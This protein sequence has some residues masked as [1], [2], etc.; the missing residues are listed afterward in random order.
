MLLK[1]VVITGIGTINPLGNNCT[2][3][4][5][6]LDNGVS[7]ASLIDRFDTSLFKT[8]F[9]C[10][11]LNFNFSDYGF[12]RKEERKNDRFSQFALVAAQEA[13]NDCGIDL[14]SENLRRIGVIVGSGVGGLETLNE[15]ISGYVAGQPP[16]YSPFLIPKIITNIAAG[17]IS[18]KYGFG[19]PNFS[20]TSACATSANAICVAHQ[21]LQLGKAN[22]MLAGGSEAPLVVCGV[23]GFNAMHALSTNN[24]EFKSASRPFDKTRDGFVMAEGAGM[25]MLEEYEHAKSRG[26]KIYAE[27]AG[28][29]MSGDSYHLTS[30]RP[31]GQGAIEAMEYALEDA[32]ITP[33]DVDYINVHGTSTILGDVAELSAVKTLFKDA[34]YKVNISST[35]SMTGHLL[36]AAG[37]VEAIACIHA[38]NDS[39]IPPTINFKVEDEEIDYKMN[40]TLNAPQHRDVRIA[41]NNNFG[42]GG[43]NACVV[44]RRFEDK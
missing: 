36:G 35:K 38:I 12:D 28:T 31:D 22:M 43:H 7:G 10:E 30:P 23:G 3:F 2:E 42:F 13:I 17:Q 25:L 5:S 26:A 16:R 15:E 11:V 29:G 6:G 37:A 34:A 24:E 27:I 39:I 19:G 4:F 8:K 33:G 44:F 40:L 1:R 20:I 14:E 18:I 41:I 9:A 21:L 32:G